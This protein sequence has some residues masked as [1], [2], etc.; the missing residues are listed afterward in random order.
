MLQPLQRWK[1][2]AEG[3]GPFSDLLDPLWK[4]LAKDPGPFFDLLD[5]LSDSTSCYG[6]PMEPTTK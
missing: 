5:P 4:A 2:L 6:K 1:A 3:T